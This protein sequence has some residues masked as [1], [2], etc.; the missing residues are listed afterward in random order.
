MVVDARRK[1]FMK[2]NPSLFLKS[3]FSGESLINQELTSNAAIVLDI[4]HL[5]VEYYINT[6]I[7]F[8]KEFPEETSAEHSFTG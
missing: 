4:S 5:D 6:I 1:D 3:E 8:W 2:K 7:N